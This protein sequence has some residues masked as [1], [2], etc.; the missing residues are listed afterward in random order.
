MHTVTASHIVVREGEMFINCPHE[1]QYMMHDNRKGRKTIR[2]P[3]MIRK[4]SQG[5]LRSP[6][7]AGSTDAR[8]WSV[9]REKV[10]RTRA[11]KTYLASSGDGTRRLPTSVERVLAL[12]VLCLLAGRVD[13][14]P[15]VGPGTIVERFLLQR[16]M[17]N[18]QTRNKMRF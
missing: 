1:K 6:S 7:C 16:I 15:N 14:G 10:Y 12:V 13:T 4:R 2:Q 5:R 17:S 3:V 9:R 8:T 11:R 18:Q